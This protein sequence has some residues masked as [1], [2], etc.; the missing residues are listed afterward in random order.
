MQQFLAC[1]CARVRRAAF[2]ESPAWLTQA[3]RRLT[4]AWLRRLLVL[5]LFFPALLR[6][7]D[8]GGKRVLILNSYHPGFVWTDALVQ[9]IQ[10]V[11]GPDTD[12]EL[13]MEYMDTKRFF[14][15]AYSA[16]L[17]DLYGL[18]YRHLPID[19]VLV[20]DDEALDF[21]L[22]YRSTLFPGVPAVFCSVSDFDESRVAEYGHITGA[23]EEYD[24]GRTLKLALRLQPGIKEVVIINDETRAGEAIGARLAKDAAEFAPRFRFRFLSNLPMPELGRSLRSLHPDTIVLALSLQRAGN[25]RTLSGLEQIRRIGQACF[26]PVYTCWDAYIGHGPVGGVVV[27]AFHQGR[28]A[29]WMVRRI[30]SGED[31]GQIPIDRRGTNIHMFDYQQLKR[32]GISESRL[33]KG[34][35]VAGKPF[36]FY[37]EYKR[38][39]W[40]VASVFSALVITLA[41]LSFNIARRRRAEAGL[42]SLFSGVPDALLVHDDEGRIL[43]CN[44]VICQRLG[45]SREEMLALSARDIEAPD[46]SKSFDTRVDMEIT[47]GR[48]SCEGV[49]VAADGRE[50]PV[51][52]NTAIITYEGKTAVLAIIRDITE[53]KEAQAELI[54]RD[55]AIASSINAIGIV[56]LTGTSWDMLYVN[57]AFLQLWGYDTAG[58]VLGR[59][60]AGFWQEPDRLAAV[61]DVVYEQGSWMGEL[62]AVRKDGSTFDVETSASVVTGE[63]GEPIC[64]MGSFIDISHRKE[65]EAAIRR[66]EA[67]F[68]ELAELLPQVV[69]EQDVSGRLTFVNR[70]A[71]RLLGLTEERIEADVSAAEAFHPEDRERVSAAVQRVL[72][73]ES[74]AG[75]ECTALR[76]DGAEMPV[77]VSASPVAGPDGQIT[78]L[79]GVIV[80]MTENR[81]AQEERRQLESRIQEAQKLESLGVLAGGVAHDFNNLLVGILGNADLALL[82]LPESSPVRPGLADIKTAAK[83][84]S[85]LTKQMLAYAGK[86]RFVV[87][88]INLNSV[89]KATAHLVEASVSRKVTLKYEI[90]K[91]LPPIEADAGQIRQALLGLVTNASEAI[92]DEPGAVTVRTGAI[93]AN[94]E[95][96]A[97]TYMGEELP[98]GRYAYLEVID[99]GGGMD[100]ETKARLFDPFFTRKFTGRGLGLAAVLGIVRGHKGAARVESELGRGT[101]F[102]MLFPS[103]QDAP[104]AEPAVADA[105]VAAA[106]V[107]G[108]VILV[109]DDEPSVRRVTKTM[110]EKNGFSV[111]LA[112]GGRQAVEMLRDQAATVDLVLLDMTMPGMDGVETFTE[113]RRIRGDVR[114]VLASG[115]TEKDATKR[116][117]GKQ[118]AG[119]VQKPFE[120]ASLLERINA[121]LNS[122]A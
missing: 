40:A 22:R 24:I 89:I 94:R 115:Y 37:R 38:L 55:K 3:R 7:A 34:S 14:G 5:L 78:G 52:I 11:L 16:Q 96:L 18:K 28:K 59:P 122:P 77:S 87:E 70:R 68:R 71:V 88:Q 48:Y 116:F 85:E 100:E 119:F 32:F 25:S 120:L 114:V 79:R 108:G 86:G 15:D 69:F 101:T 29:A 61:V 56:D 41:V 66:S 84:A 1:R 27:S 57:P 83:R 109:V 30:L 76:E 111:L 106:P 44:E 97:T 102:R 92:A 110:L 43:H 74:L 51:D 65:S 9:G 72:A 64:F 12:T 93:Q 98:E 103:L 19:A 39:V 45:Y 20:C 54:V 67:R 21:L 26:V 42:R 99:T 13:L 53:R 112:E 35:V 105:A 113:I 117:R 58:D 46:F 118:L 4:R 2:A 104:P 49:H 80:D 95:Y 73:G 81:R 90:D 75:L 33:P 23:T 47:D 8:A 60:A 6:A 31:A 10:S 107:G 36:S 63:H 50:I 121:A 17:R 82:D 62:T 91:D